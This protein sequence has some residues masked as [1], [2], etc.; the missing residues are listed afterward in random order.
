VA[1]SATFLRL[2]L[3]DKRPVFEAV[4][5]VFVLGFFG[6]FIFHIAVSENQP[7]APARIPSLRIPKDESANLLPPKLISVPYIYP[8]V[9]GFLEKGVFRQTQNTIEHF[10]PF[11]S[12]R[13]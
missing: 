9:C 2:F 1:F 5:R 7:V 13:A 4:F 12:A 6:Y 8:I 11:L 10:L 3:V